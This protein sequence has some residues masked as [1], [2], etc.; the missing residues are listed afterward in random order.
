MPLG[1][2]QSIPGVRESFDEPGPI[3]APQCG[4]W[5]PKLEHG[6]AVIERFD[7]MRRLDRQCFEVDRGEDRRLCTGVAIPIGAEQR[8]PEGDQR[9][10]VLL[11]EDLVRPDGLLE[12]LAVRDPALERL[13][14]CGSILATTRKSREKNGSGYRCDGGKAVTE[15]DAP[16]PAYGAVVG[17][18]LDTQ[19]VL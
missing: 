1:L 5:R 6:N 12:S 13:R 11:C 7:L 18:L 16:A 15:P 17:Q 8:V 19:R 2:D 14:R 3:V 9:S 4:V 10:L